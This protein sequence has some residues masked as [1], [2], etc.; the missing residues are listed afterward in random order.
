MENPYRRTVYMWAV[1]TVAAVAIIFMPG[2]LGVDGMSGGYAISFV[3]FFGAI[4]GVVVV[5]VYNGLSTRFDAIVGGMDVL[6]RW[7]YPSELWKKYSDAEYE[8]SVAE[9]K[10]LFI[11]TS[12]MC[13]IAGVGAV[14]WDPEPGIYVLGIM[15]FTIILMGLAAF[16]TR[17]HLH[18]DNL[19]NLGEA[20]I[21]KK[22]VLLNNRLFYWD[23]F[24]SKLEKVELRKDKDYSV[25]IFTTWAP[26]MQFGQSYSLRVPVPPGEEARASEIASTMKTD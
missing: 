6:A 3:S 17:R 1:I 21:S 18:H 5:L 14:L 16:L 23:Y 24:G 8:E 20:I 25:L 11:L 2:F 15:V 13:L 7:T 4:V 9:V 19:R 12:A 26:T 10:P 22:A